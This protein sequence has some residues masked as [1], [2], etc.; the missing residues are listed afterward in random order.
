MMRYKVGE[1]KHTSLHRVKCL[2]CKHEWME[3][4]YRDKTLKFCEADTS[5]RYNRTNKKIKCPICGKK[6]LI[7]PENEKHYI[8]KLKSEKHG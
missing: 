6:K 8:K 2:S 1:I 4:V 7:F 3:P 5:V